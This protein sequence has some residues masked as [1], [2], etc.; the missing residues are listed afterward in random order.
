[1]ERYIPCSL[2]GNL[3]IV[4]LSV[5]PKLM[6]RFHAVSINILARY[7]V[8]IKKLILTLMWKGKNL[9]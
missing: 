6:Y 5:L 3:N 2:I 1:M 7:F 9:E 4:K 8:A